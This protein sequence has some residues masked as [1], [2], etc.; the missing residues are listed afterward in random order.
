MSIIITAD[1]KPP[2]GGMGGSIHD[3]ERSKDPF[4]RECMPDEFQ[5]YFPKKRASTGWL[6]LDYWGNAIGFVED[7]AVWG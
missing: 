6:A 2:L 1:T 7:G 4:A 3:W 5:S